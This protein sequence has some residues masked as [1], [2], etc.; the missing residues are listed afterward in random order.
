[1]TTDIESD[2]CSDHVFCSV[3][4]LI[5][6][7]CFHSSFISHVVLSIITSTIKLLCRRLKQVRRLT[8]QCWVAQYSV[9]SHSSFACHLILV[10]GHSAAGRI[11]SGSSGLIGEAS[12]SQRSQWCADHSQCSF[13]ARV[14]AVKGWI[15]KG[16]WRSS[17]VRA[18][19]RRLGHDSHAQNGLA[20]IQVP[21]AGMTIVRTS[22]TS[23]SHSISFREHWQTSLSTSVTGNIWSSQKQNGQASR[24]M[25][26]SDHPDSLSDDESTS[27]STSAVMVF[28]ILSNAVNRYI[29]LKVAH[30]LMRSVTRKALLVMKSISSSSKERVDCYNHHVPYWLKSKEACSRGHLDSSFFLI[31]RHCIICISC[32]NAE[33]VQISEIPFRS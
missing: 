24:A 18:S 2:V 7:S 23:S 5:C 9:A 26:C 27:P 10:N 19:G 32:S 17:R 20:T 33:T 21:W 6:V 3:L 1:M 13:T 11:S 28:S 16:Y 4:Y 29:Y 31:S 25:V 14:K 8:P 30:S 12:R 15:L 22:S